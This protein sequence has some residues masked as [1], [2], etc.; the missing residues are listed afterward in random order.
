MIV[1]AHELPA[2]WLKA[3]RAAA[4]HLEIRTT[5]DEPD[6]RDVAALLCAWSG[7]P[8]LT[9]FPGLRL[10]QCLGAGVDHVLMRGAVPEGV[11]VAR[12]VSDAQPGSMSAYI[13]LHV[14]RRQR[15]LADLQARHERREWIYELDASAGETT[16]GILGAGRLGRDAARKLGLVGFD[17]RT[18]SGSRAVIPDV[19]S[20]A[21][22]GE[23]SA[24]LA[25]TRHL[26]CLLPLTSAT[27][28]ILN[29]RLFAALPAGA[30]LI[31]VGR[32]EHLVESDL[33]PALESGR[34]AGA[35]LDVMG[36]EPVPPDHPFWSDP[37][38]LITPHTASTVNPLDVV[39]QIVANLDRVAVGGTPENV[40]DRTRGY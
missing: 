34:L 29:A 2:F 3:L 26:V 37:R 19:S 21:G 9:S 7:P 17:V 15:R 32:G 5:V 40:V 13:L 31:N 30:F 35:T 4:P 16:V 27:R 11:A 14:L 36:E 6:R 38:I 33:I 28:G 23:L 10:V 22:A 24:F 25:G 20:F 39:P 18:W 12:T 8:D 1:L